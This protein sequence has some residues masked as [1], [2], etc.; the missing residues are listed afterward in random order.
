MQGQQS[1]RPVE[2][3]W[4]GPYSWPGY[5]GENDLRPLPKVVPGVYLQTFEYQGGYLIYG[6]GLTRRP[7]PERF[8]QHTRKYMNGEY[9]VLDIAAAQ[10]G[11][12]SEVWH[13]WGYARTHREEFEE[14]RTTIVD[15]VRKQLAGFRLFIPDTI[16]LS[17]ETRVPERLE[18]AIFDALKRQPS[19]ICDIPDRRMH[20]APRR[21]TENP[22]VIRNNCA[23][24]L[25]GLPALLEV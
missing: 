2:V 1:G 10:Q 6:P 22:I 11:V 15:A 5:E 18:A 3:R 23:D 14:R 16:D 21:D 8:K 17:K 7:A 4:V 13:G 20:R 24:L 12:R 19:P 9:N 25:H